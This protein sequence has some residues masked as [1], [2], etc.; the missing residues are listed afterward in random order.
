VDS[1]LDEYTTSGKPSF[2]S[3]I[4]QCL[5]FIGPQNFTRYALAIAPSVQE[6]RTKSSVHGVFVHRLVFAVRY[7]RFHELMEKREYQDAA[8]DL[9]AI[10]SENVA[11]TSW[12]AVV[13]Y[14][15]AS[16]LRYGKLPIFFFLCRSKV[17][18]VGPELLFSSTG[19]MLLLQKLEEIFIQASQGAGND[20]LTVLI[21]VVH[22]K[23]EKDALDRLRTV[24]VAIAQYFARCSVIDGGVAS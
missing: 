13:L 7:A 16:L 23:G 22:G 21:R 20:Y 9:I 6:L 8:S 17:S 1:V 14:D 10:F 11:P 24:R 19:A 5:H 2:L 4:S 3:R 15:S 12:W 18:C